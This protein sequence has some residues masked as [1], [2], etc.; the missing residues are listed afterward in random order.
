MF[1]PED[2]LFGCVELVLDTQRLL[3]S[4][5]TLEFFRILLPYVPHP[6]KRKFQRGAENH[7]KSQDQ[8]RPE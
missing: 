6:S 7:K 4:E 1:K 5:E 8:A 3:K 2:D